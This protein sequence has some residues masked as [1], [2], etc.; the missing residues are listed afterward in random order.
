MSLQ[1]SHQPVR[2]TT[3]VHR[4]LRLHDCARRCKVSRYG[5]IAQLA[6]RVADN[7][8]VPGSSPGGPINVSSESSE[9]A[10]IPTVW[11]SGCYGASVHLLVTKPAASSFDEPSQS[12]QTHAGDT[13]VTALAGSRIARCSHAGG[14][15]RD[16]CVAALAVKR[17]GLR[18]MTGCSDRMVRELEPRVS[19]TYRLSALSSSAAFRTNARSAHQ[20]L[21]GN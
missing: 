17:G 6:E 16:E 3:V 4:R 11:W 20:I 14:G 10:A 12:P 9:V 2:A 13:T 5:L 8:E 7:D 19:A 18:R 15:F 1:V 21:P